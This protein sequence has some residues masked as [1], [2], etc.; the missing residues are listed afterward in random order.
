MPL[1][2]IDLT[3]KSLGIN[4]GADRELLSSKD[5]KE[6]TLTNLNVQLGGTNEKGRVGRST[7]VTG[8]G[9]TE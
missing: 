7:S 5:D 3:D 2:L 4:S 8:G 1:I 6:A 9:Q